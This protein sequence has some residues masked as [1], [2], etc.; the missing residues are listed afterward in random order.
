M[1]PFAALLLMLFLGA[2][3]A[4]Q[5]RYFDSGGVRLRYLERGSGS[6]VILLHGFTGQLE[7]PWVDHGLFDDLAR[8]HR[9]VAFDLRGHG[10]SGK[11][12]EPAAY[13]DI[14]LDT[15]R[16]MDHLGIARAHV[17]GYSLGG[18]IAAKLLTT[19]PQR[20]ASAV[21]AGA[22]HRRGRGTQMDLAVEADA[23]ELERGPLPYRSLILST[24]PTDEPPLSAEGLVALSA[25]I[26][27]RS[28]RLAHAALLRGRDALLVLDEQLAKVR[29]PALAI[30]G[31][32]DPALPR[33]Q[34]MVSKW[35]AAR[36]L[37]VPG[38]THPV[39]HPRSLAQRAEFKE[40]VRSFI[41]ANDSGAASSTPPTLSS[42]P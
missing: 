5:D 1:R 35:P 24:A 23:V 16:L 21:I 12:H 10:E 29:V 22:S 25:A 6:A 31:S 30:V 14:G 28:D 20:F 13:A 38:A 3:A 18:I 40:A 39:L 36:L 15:I 33:I 9:V 19:D 17:V 34:R 2:Q 26:A 4:A 41:A 37:V 7:R 27:G 8:G 11:P 42:R 32:A